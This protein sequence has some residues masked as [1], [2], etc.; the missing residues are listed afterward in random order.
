MSRTASDQVHKLI[1]SLTSAEIR[2][3]KIFSSRHYDANDTHYVKLFDA[4]AG[5]GQYDEAAILEKFKKEKFIKLFSITK[6]RLYESVMRSLDMF[7]AASSVD[8]ELKREIHYAEILYKKTLYDLCAKTLASAKKFAQKYERYSA[9][10]DI[11]LWEKKLIEKDNYSGK[12]EEDINTFLN[13]DT[14]IGE[15]IN[16]FN[17]H[18]NIK[19][20]LFMILNKQ[21]KARTKDELQRFKKIIDSTL[22]NAESES[23]SAE[24]KYLYHHIYSAYFFGVGDYE[25]CY[26]YLKKNVVLI[27]NSKHIFEEE[28]NIYFSVL[29][30][31]IYV[32]SQ[33]KKFDEA[34]LYVKKLREVPATF[35]IRKN[36][37]MEI[38]LFS[39][40]FSIEITLY[41]TLGDFEKAM[42]L[43][44]AIEDG[45]EKY[46]GKI[47]KLREAYF[48]SSIA[49]AY[50]GAE[51]YSQALRW[52]NKILND[53]KIEQ[54]EGIHCFA[55]IFNLI[56][57]IE[58]KNETLIPYTY[59]STHRYLKQKE[60]EYKFENVFMKFVEKLMNEKQKKVLADHYHA[61]DMDLKSLE[62]DGLEQPV[63]EF[64]D[65]AAWAHSKAKNRY[66]REIVAEKA[67][68]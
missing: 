16:S 40:S 6:A 42:E 46:S 33:L 17:D 53:K 26:S 45:L 37:D 13:E 63:F 29:T 11:Y 36:E 21:G 43:I 3:F 38:K 67:G 39:S 59:R 50:F 61:L 32:C 27:E 1:Q 2:Y 28:P 55:K 31:I 30:N 25:K 9:L 8:A 22:L 51:K 57:H 56:I 7:H 19:S 52:N 54:H 44:P 35:D 14:L 15:K 48:Y 60:R 65:F 49:V 18:W 5:Q 23:L 34:F 64:F 62:K 68:K 4:I 20:R 58:L 10:H 47:N 24:T 41:N 66:F 12:T